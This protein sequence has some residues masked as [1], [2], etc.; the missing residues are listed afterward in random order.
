MGEQR[1]AVGQHHIEGAV[2][3][4]AGNDALEQC[5]QLLAARRGVAEFA[6]HALQQVAEGQFAV[7]GADRTKGA[8]EHG[9]E[10]LQVAVMGEHPVAAPQLAHEGMAVFQ[11]HVADG[12]LADVGDDVGRLDRITLDQ[13]GDR[14]GDG[15]LVIDEVAHATALEEGDSP[16]VVV[17]VG[18][19]AAVGE[20]GK[21][22]DN[23]GGDIAVHSEELAHA[24][25]LPCRI[26]KAPSPAG[27]NGARGLQR[28]RPV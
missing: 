25:S 2:G 21:R 19:A 10:I 20:A 16:A 3:G 14:R 17:G 26:K 7:G 22:E 18:T 6:A 28:S 23:V 15:G 4:D 24:R 27:G 8:V 11:R 13:F 9:R 5:A 12:G 1:G